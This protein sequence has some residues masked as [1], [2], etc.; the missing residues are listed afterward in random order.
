MRKR[1]QLSLKPINV[2]TRYLNRGSTV[3]H[4]WIPLPT[5]LLLFVKKIAESHDSDCNSKNRGIFCFSRLRKFQNE[6]LKKFD[7]T[8]ENESVII[9]I[10]WNFE[11]LN[12]SKNVRN[13]HARESSNETSPF[14]WN[15]DPRLLFF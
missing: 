14:A 2:Y 15:H 6:S 10:N 4:Q 8:H 1:V 12:I 3:H 11:E 5:T 7:E 13:I 9:C